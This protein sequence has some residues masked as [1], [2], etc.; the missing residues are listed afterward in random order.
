MLELS[1]M[2]TFSNASIAGAEVAKDVGHFPQ[3]FKE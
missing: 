3:M 2:L 1:V